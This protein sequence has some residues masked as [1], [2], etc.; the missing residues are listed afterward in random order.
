MSVL[1]MI[2]V[3]AVA[4]FWVAS[5]W[6]RQPRETRVA[7]GG[8]LQDDETPGRALNANVNP[9]QTGNEK[10]LWP[11][12]TGPQTRK[13]LGA[14]QAVD[15]TFVGDK[16]EHKAPTQ[17]QAPAPALAPERHA[18]QEA[19]KRAGVRQEVEPGPHEHGPGTNPAADLA[20]ED[21]FGED[22]PAPRT[23][24]P[25]GQQPTQWHP[26]DHGV[27]GDHYRD[28]HHRS[29]TAPEKQSSATDPYAHAPVPGPN[30]IPP[31]DGKELPPGTSP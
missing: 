5:L 6:R 26:V 21:E 23:T 19:L 24:S 8:R 16:E 17:A 18:T 29:A 30:H 20:P 2:A 10:N 9:S 7:Q 14:K 4:V 15:R 13:E 22:R 3:L 27:P 31:S 28:G 11:D 12:R 1:L 25:D